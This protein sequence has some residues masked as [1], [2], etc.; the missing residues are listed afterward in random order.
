ME[1]T[2]YTRVLPLQ[3][4]Y[5]VRDLGGYRT[6]DGKTVKWKKVI[7]SGD[8]NKLSQSD[9]DCLE[10]VGLKTFVDFRSKQEVEAAPDKTVPGVSEKVWLP[11]VPGDMIAA[12][13]TIKP[14]HLPRLIE[15]V[16]VNIIRN[17]SNEYRQLFELLAAQ[18]HLPLLFHCSAGKDRTGIGA[19]LF[20]SSLGVDRQVIMQDYLLSNECLKG[21]Y[22]FILKSYPQYEP[23]TTVRPAYLQKAFEVIDTEYSG[24]ENYLTNEL[25]VDLK[26]MRN[27]YL[28]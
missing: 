1:Q 27:S 15:E 10:S 21:K 18:E 11:I 12:I 26:W 3:D 6:L 14:D 20:L 19:A 8:L 28:E 17:Y 5:N 24:M 25:G 13:G 4:A 23:L 7:R 2:N 22:D 16:Y 9:V